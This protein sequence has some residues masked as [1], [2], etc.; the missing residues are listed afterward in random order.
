[1]RRRWALLPFALAAHPLHT[2]LATL[3]WNG[4]RRS[5]E[6]A[7]RV[8]TQDLS[9]AVARQ[10]TP[11]GVVSDSVACRYAAG[12]LSI[13]NAAGQSL[14][15]A[16]CTTTRA[17]GVTWIRLTFPVESAA[18]LHVRSAFLFERFADQI[19]IVQSTVGHGMRTIL[20]TAG[21]GPKPLT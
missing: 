10:G 15:A 4:D 21:D 20:F 3:A 8:F 2:T 19:N 18:G 13:R 6:V 1:M 16:T 14:D 5:L 12:A 11:A 17:A 7:V 9:D